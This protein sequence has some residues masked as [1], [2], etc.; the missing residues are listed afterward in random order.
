[1]P[2]ITPQDP[3]NWIVYLYASNTRV[4]DVASNQDS[5]V[6]LGQFP[7]ETLDAG[8]PKTPAWIPLEIFGMFPTDVG[9]RELRD[10]AG[11]LKVET[12]DMRLGGSMTVVPF[13]F[14]DTLAEYFTALRAFS[15]KYKYLWMNDYDAAGL[16]IDTPA[17]NALRFVC[18]TPQVQSEDAEKPFVVNWFKYGAE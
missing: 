2:L 13:D 11:R 7:P 9:E 15:K 1:M 16:I 3:N 8:V 12:G 4:G 5:C 10:R 17:E 18:E 14:N 6:P